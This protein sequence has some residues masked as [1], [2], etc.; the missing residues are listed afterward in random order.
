[1]SLKGWYGKRTEAI[2][3]RGKLQLS[4]TLSQTTTGTKSA[5]LRVLDPF[6]KDGT[7]GAILPI[8]FTGSRSNL[9]D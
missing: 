9:S 7:R 8:N 1:V 6:F 3:F 4:S 2:N 5:L